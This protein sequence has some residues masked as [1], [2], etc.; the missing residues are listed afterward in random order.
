MKLYT[1][2]RYVKILISLYLIETSANSIE[3]NR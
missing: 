2:H 3:K 1:H